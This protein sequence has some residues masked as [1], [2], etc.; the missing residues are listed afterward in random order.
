[1]IPPDMDL[2]LVVQ[3]P[4]DAG[5]LHSDVWLLNDVKIGDTVSGFNGMDAGLDV[6]RVQVCGI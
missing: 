2:F 3:R 6:K 5:R 4:P 1:M